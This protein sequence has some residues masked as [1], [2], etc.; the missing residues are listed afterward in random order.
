MRALRIH[1]EDTVATVLADVEEGDE[2]T[3]ISDDGKTL[4]AIVATGAIPMAH[5]VSLE[6]TE[7]GEKIVKYG[8][9]VGRATHSIGKGAHV[10]THNV[11]SMRVR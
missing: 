3:V 9:V 11:E 2:V 8:E 4:R 1:P 5:K 7:V 6:K 10:H